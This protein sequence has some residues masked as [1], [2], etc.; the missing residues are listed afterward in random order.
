MATVSVISADVG[1]GVRESGKVGVSVSPSPCIPFAL[2]PALQWGC[3]DAWLI[4][5]RSR[6]LR[7]TAGCRAMSTAGALRQSLEGLD[8]WRPR[9]P[10]RLGCFLTKHPG[11]SCLDPQT[12]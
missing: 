11:P 12:S 2:P 6:S 4:V 1:T 9:V 10:P 5:Q 8:F 7:K 3:L